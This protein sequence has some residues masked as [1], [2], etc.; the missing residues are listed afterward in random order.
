MIVVS[1]RALERTM[2]EKKKKKRW[3]L[4][5]QLSLALVLP[6]CTNVEL[7][8]S[9]LNDPETFIWR[10]RK[11]SRI[12]ASQGRLSISIHSRGPVSTRTLGV[13]AAPWWGGPLRVS[14]SPP[15]SPAK[16]ENCVGRHEGFAFTRI[17]TVVCCPVSV[18]SAFSVS[19]RSGQCVGRKTKKQKPK[20]KIA[21]PHVH[22]CVCFP[23]ACA[24][25]LL[26]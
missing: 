26:V 8:R 10:K 7:E 1:P 3:K 4:R 9:L 24:C 2:N 13:L 15:N 20:K 6:C 21:L 14:S 18:T 11:K 19:I 16:G 23:A 17:V 12:K 25:F 22:A 5:M